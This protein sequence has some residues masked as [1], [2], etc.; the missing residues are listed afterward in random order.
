MLETGLE[1]LPRLIADAAEPL[2]DI[3]DRT[4]GEFFDRF[5]DALGHARGSEPRDERILSRS[6]GDLAAP[7]HSPTSGRAA[8]PPPRSSQFPA[9]QC[10]SPACA[11]FPRAHAAGAYRGRGR[12][13]RVRP[14]CALY[15]PPL[16][17]FDAWVWF[18][19]TSAVVRYRASRGRVG[20]CTR[21]RPIH[22]ACRN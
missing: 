17:Q 19:E 16:H 10:G 4:F 22:S 5:V 12:V 13:L 18:D 9:G 8:A 1:L 2:P 6:S 21:T 14:T 11:P 3:D 20:G 7:R 15:R